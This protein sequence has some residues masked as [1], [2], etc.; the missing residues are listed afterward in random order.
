MNKEIIVSTLLRMSDTEFILQ[1]GKSIEDYEDAYFSMASKSNDPKKSL[2]LGHMLI[3]EIDKFI[4]DRK[5]AIKKLICIRLNYCESKFK[6]GHTE[7]V[8]VAISVCDCLI[9]FAVNCPVPI[10]L[11]SCYL[12]RK[13]ILDKLCQCT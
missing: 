4:N 7:E 11:L 3:K 2:D 1:L 10:L 13:R 9:I 6:H 8:Q 5:K 12:I